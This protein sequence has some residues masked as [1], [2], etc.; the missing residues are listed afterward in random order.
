MEK[1]TKDLLIKLK[2]PVESDS[3]DHMEILYD[4]YWKCSN[5]EKILDPIRSYYLSMEDVPELNQKQNWNKEE[6]EKQRKPL[7]NT[8]K[9]LVKIID[10]L[11]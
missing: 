1:D 7:K 11:L 2:T 8:H 6:F 5:G 4:L 3:V 10:E 9:E